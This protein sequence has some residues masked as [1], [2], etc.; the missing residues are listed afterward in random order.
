MFTNNIPKH[1]AYQEV[2]LGLIKKRVIVWSSIKSA[3]KKLFE[4]L[5]GKN[6]F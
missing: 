4:E 2:R 6:L 3:I 1:R 5:T